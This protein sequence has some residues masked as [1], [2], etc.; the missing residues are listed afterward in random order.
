MHAKHTAV[1]N[2]TERHVVKHVAAVAPDV[3]TAILSCALVVEAVHLGNLPRLVVAPDERH[4]VRVSDFERQQQQECLD[5]V[6]AA[7]HKVAEKQVVGIR[8]HAAHTEQL[9]EI[10]KLAVNVAT[11][12]H[13]RV[14]ALDVGLLDENVARLR[15]EL[16]HLRLR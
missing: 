6:Q 16:L 10:V 7:V 13:G 14:H 4:P 12:G 2:R 15:T 11:D 3:R 1:H 9:H 5:R 8:A